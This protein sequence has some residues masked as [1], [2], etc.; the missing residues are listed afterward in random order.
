M[1]MVLMAATARAD[2]LVQ[3]VV[4]AVVVFFYRQTAQSIIVRD[5][6]I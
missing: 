6:L 1:Q 5:P 2:Q 3:A 4:A